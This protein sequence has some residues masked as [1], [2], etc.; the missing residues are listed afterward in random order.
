MI[1]NLLALLLALQKTT[2]DANQRPLVTQLSDELETISRKSS[3]P[4]ED[5]EIVQTKINQLL[6]KNST[7]AEQYQ[8]TLSQLQLETDERLMALL[9]SRQRI[10]LPRSHAPK[11][12]GQ[13]PTRDGNID[14][15]EPNERNIIKIIDDMVKVILSDKNS[16]TKESL[17]APLSEISNKLGDR[18]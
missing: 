3:A 15:T 8:Q 9:L 10:N 7:F 1:K 6:E 16:E 17:L 4:E 11:V 14:P 2:L 12:L 13:S 18:K 5:W